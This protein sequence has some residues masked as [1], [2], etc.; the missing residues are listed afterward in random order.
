MKTKLKAM[1]F[2]NKKVAKRKGK[3]LRELGLCVDIGFQSGG[4]LNS[5]LAS[6][7]QKKKEETKK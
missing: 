3:L 6:H 2:A 7:V 4:S 1:Q 5:V